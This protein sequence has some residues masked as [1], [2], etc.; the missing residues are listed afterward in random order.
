MGVTITHVDMTD[1]ENLRGAISSKTRVVYFETPANPN[2]RLVDTRAVAA[3]A[4]EAGAQVLV[5]NTYAPPIWLTG[6]NSA[7]ITASP[8]PLTETRF[9]N[10]SLNWIPLTLPSQDKRKA[11]SCIR[12]WTGRASVL[13]RRGCSIS[14]PFPDVLP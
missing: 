4:H 13:L 11:V 5:D 9:P 2:M 3:I 10:G 1:A 8:C 7:A 12:L 6:N 14:S